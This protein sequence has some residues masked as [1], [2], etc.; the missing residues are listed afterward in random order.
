MNQYAQ[1]LMNQNAWGRH[2]QMGQQLYHTLFNHHGAG[3][4]ASPAMMNNAMQQGIGQ[5]GN[6]LMSGAQG[7]ASGLA[8]G[9]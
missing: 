7:A 8:G 4:G 3:A 2:Y 9:K 1:Y 5:M 6:S